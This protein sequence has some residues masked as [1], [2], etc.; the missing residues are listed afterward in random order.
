ME[1]DGIP[2]PYLNASLISV[3]KRCGIYYESVDIPYRSDYQLVN[4]NHN[5]FVNIIKDINTLTEAIYQG[6]TKYV[7]SNYK[8]L[9]GKACQVIALNTNIDAYGIGEIVK[10]EAEATYQRDLKEIEAKKKETRQRAIKEAERREQREEFLRKVDRKMAELVRELRITVSKVYKPFTAIGLIAGLG[11]AG[12][13]GAQYWIK[14]ESAQGQLANVR[15][16]NLILTTENKELA[17]YK[18]VKSKMQNITQ[19]VEVLKEDNN[20]IKTKNKSL[21]QEI[22][23][24]YNEN[25]NLRKRIERCN[26]GF[27]RL[28]KC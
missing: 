8:Q 24:I 2:I 28:G 7:P 13:L 15:S 22:T 27:L 23:R 20:K 10:T 17:K 11:Y 5:S 25:S 19:E 9:F 18:D 3:A 26:S 12:W 16:Q 14:E 4:Y 1:F 6:A 21:E